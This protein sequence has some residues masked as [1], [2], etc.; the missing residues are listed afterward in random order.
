MRIAGFEHPRDGVARAP[1]GIECR[2]VVAQPRVG[3][4]RVGSRDGEQVATAFVQLEVDVAERLEPPA[5][6]AARAPDALGDRA[7]APAHRGI[8]M[9]DPVG[10]AVAHR[11]QD[12]RFCPQRAHYTL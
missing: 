12:H 2:A 11:P 3:V 1:G 4:D 8:E 10:L 7:D 5:E 6:A 9:Q